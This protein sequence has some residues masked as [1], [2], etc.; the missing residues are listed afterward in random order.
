MRVALLLLLA[1]AAANAAERP[2]IASKSEIGFSVKQMGVAVSGEFKRFTAKVD[3]DPKKPE[4]GSAE[5][6]VD[7]A[8]VSTG[9][10]EGDETAI[11]KAWLDAAGFPKATFKSTSVRGLGG[12]AHGCASAAGA[13]CAGAADRYEAKGLLTIKNKPREITV[14]F[15]LTSQA[16]G[17]SVVAGDFQIR[18]ADFGVGGGEWNQGDLVANEVP[19]HFRLTLGAAR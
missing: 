19:I 3:L 13:G 17:G 18:R 12:A 10:D 11:D 9:T 8:S 7:V 5:I 1:C 14:P 2:L 6:V 16:D 4:S 15:T